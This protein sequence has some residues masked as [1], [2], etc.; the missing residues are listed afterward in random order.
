MK[1]LKTNP[2]KKADL[3]KE[4]IREIARLSARFIKTTK[5]CCASVS[6]RY[7]SRLRQKF[8]ATAMMLMQRTF[9]GFFF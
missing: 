6:G 1:N 3:D 8:W 5:N 7:F 9:N 2:D 4:L